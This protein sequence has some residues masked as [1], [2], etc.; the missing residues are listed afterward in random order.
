MHSFSAS[1]IPEPVGSY[2]SNQ[3]LRPVALIGCRATEIP[4]DCCEYDLA[5][6]SNESRK[7]E[8]VNVEG[9]SVEVLYLGNDP[10]NYVV[11]LHETAIL[12]DT[13][14]FLLAS[15]KKEMTREKYRRALSAAGRKSLIGSLLCQQRMIESTGRP[16]LAAMWAKLACYRFI[17]GVLALSGKRPMPLH[18]LEQVRQ[19]D[20]PASVADGIQAAL[21]CIGMERATRPAIS[22]SIEAV[23]ELKSKEYD[24]RLVVSKIEYLLERQMLADCYYYM[25][26]VAAAT[27]ARKSSSFHTRYS[28]LIQ[29]SMDLTSDVQHLQNLQRRLFRAA[30]ACLK[31]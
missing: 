31:G 27:L 9:Y 14:K 30:N 24:N 29:I 11:E 21:D 17:A 16:V 8:V 19:T 12:E 2:A 1:S 28:K 23:R 22:R 10:R 15:A 18:E 25:G 4:H 6:F 20:S 3:I 5:V 7:N 13:E 26:R